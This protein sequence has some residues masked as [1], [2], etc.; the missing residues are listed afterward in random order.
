MR[1]PT[2]HVLSDGKQMCP[3]FHQNRRV[4]MKRSQCVVN[5]H[6]LTHTHTHTYFLT[7]SLIHRDAHPLPVTPRDTALLAHRA[8]HRHRP[9]IEHSHK[10]HCACVCVCVCLST[11]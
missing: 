8:H 11:R 2:H 9:H 6:D 1:H 4:C 5:A 7:H 3:S 10:A